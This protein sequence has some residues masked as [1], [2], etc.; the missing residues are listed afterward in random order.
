MTSSII[1]SKFTCSLSNSSLFNTPV[2]FNAAFLSNTPTFVNSSF[3]KTNASSLDKDSASTA[4]AKSLA[5]SL[6]L[7][8]GP[9]STS[10]SSA[11]GGFESSNC[12][13]LKASPWNFVFLTKR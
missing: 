13:P 2:F 8:R 7:P 11:E 4:F 10:R 12:R 5:I 1:S 9:N 6:V 3:T